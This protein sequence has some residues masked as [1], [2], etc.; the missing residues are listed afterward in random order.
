MRMVANE[1]R[2]RAEPTWLQGRFLA[3]AGHD[4]SEETYDAGEASSVM[5]QETPEFRIFRNAGYL[6]VSDIGV[7]LISAA[8]AVFVARYLGP[9]LYG[10][11]AVAL[12]FAGV[13]GY[14]TDLGVTQVMI[15]EGT[16]PGVNIPHL[17]AGALRL[18][19]LLALGTMVGSSLVV[20]L[21]YPSSTLRLVI[22]VVTVPT[23]WA[24]VFRGVAS[25]YF[26]M[27]QEM[28]YTALTHAVAGLVG[29]GT[30]SCGVLL[31]WPL[32]ALAVAYG[33]SAGIAAMVGL[34]LVLRR[35]PI[36]GGW[37]GGLF[38]GLTAFT[39][40][41]FLTMLIP[42]LG[43]LLLPRVA[44]L[45]TT[46]NFAAAYRI[47]GVLYAVPGVVATAF[48]PQLFYYGARE[49]YD[50]HLQLC[51]RQVT[52][53]GFLGLLMAIPFSFQARWVMG[54]VFGEEWVEQ[55]GP[56]LTI[57][58][59]GVA[60]QSL[61]VPLGDALTTLGWQKRRVVVQGGA[62]LV[63]AGLIWG[64]GRPWGATGAAVGTLMG[65]VATVAGFL[66]CNP[67]KGVLV[68]HLVHSLVVKLAMG[69]GASW[70]ITHLMGTGLVPF[71]LTAGAVA[72]V[73]WA[74]DKEIRRYA[75]LIL[76]H[77][78]RVTKLERC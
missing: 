11:L 71:V 68:R 51:K 39:A 36:R 3:S 66:A 60:L 12:A 22:L 69:L 48:Y 38:H 62:A 45:N 74:V 49:E 54:V 56:T 44:G 1:L 7:R 6:V 26:Q 8:A 72:G 52:I 29:A 5:Q 53:M 32:S 17:L 59:W 37:Y 14:F 47:P 31:R 58:A 64:L 13:A 10:I 67:Q 61:G 15:R 50:K 18:R 33:L 4:S 9:E 78:G 70:A 25:A 19:I 73:G 55:G 28:R 76:K 23:I 46:G 24:G 41:G 21:C 42:Q 63:G 16:K 34:A 77:L 43:P 2:Q 20:W 35:T 30:L 27:I 65:G 57:L 40:G 75:V